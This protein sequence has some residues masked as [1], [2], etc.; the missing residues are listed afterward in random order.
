MIKNSK[1]DTQPV[2]T[3]GGE[4]ISVTAHTTAWKYLGTRFNGTLASNKVVHGYLRILL[5]PLTKVPLKP[6][7]SLVALSHYLVPRL[8][9]RLVLGLV[10]STFLQS[11]D[12]TIRAAV[13]QWLTL[14]ADITL[15]LFYAPV[16]EGGLRAMCL[17][18]VASGSLLFSYHYLCAVAAS[19]D[20]VRTPTAQAESWE[21]SGR[22]S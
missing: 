18:M 9:R 11:L 12:K 14:P 3:I 21:S 16:P 4:H 5:S 22:T 13:R 17:R 6:Q 10:S 7:Q 15:G 19:K 20:F 1:A 8:M 2:Y